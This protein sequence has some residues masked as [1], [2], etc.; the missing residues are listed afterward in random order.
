MRYRCCWASVPHARSV[1]AIMPRPITYTAVGHVE[2]ALFLA[3]DHLLHRGAVAA[4][5]LGLP[6]DAGETGVELQRLPPAGP[7]E[8][9]LAAGLEHGALVA[10]GGVGD[11][12]CVGLE[13]GA[14]FG[15]PGGFFG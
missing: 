8:I 13:P 10:V 1:G 12:R 15:A 5:E 6:R 11:R 9:G 3:E 14:A 4:A 7:L 2:T